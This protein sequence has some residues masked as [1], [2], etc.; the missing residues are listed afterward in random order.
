MKQS[1]PSKYGTLC[2]AAIIL[3]SIQSNAK[4]DTLVISKDS[5]T[6]KKAAKR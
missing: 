1:S 2:F 5:V 4:K 6:K 3:F